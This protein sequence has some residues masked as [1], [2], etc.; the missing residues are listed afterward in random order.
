VA[1]TFLRGG[2]KLFSVFS[3]KI[4]SAVK[5]SGDQKPKGAICSDFPP[6]VSA[7]PECERQQVMD[8]ASAWGSVC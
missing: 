3:Q 5:P 1:T 4:A 6:I 2:T 7:Q 8:E